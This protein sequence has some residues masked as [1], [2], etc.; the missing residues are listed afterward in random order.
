MVYYLTENIGK[1]FFKKF[2][3]YYLTENIGKIFFFFK[4]IP[5]YFAENFKKKSKNFV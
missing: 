5:Y 2:K 4:K 3:T 1:I